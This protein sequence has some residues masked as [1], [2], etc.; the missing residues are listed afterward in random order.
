MS[1]LKIVFH[2]RAY[3]RPPLSLPRGAPRTALDAVPHWFDSED[4]RDRWRRG[5]AR[6][7][8]ECRAAIEEALSTYAEGREPSSTAPAR[9]ACTMLALC[10]RPE[11]TGAFVTYWYK[12]AGF[13]LLLEAIALSWLFQYHQSDPD[14]WIERVATAERFGP[15]PRYLAD[16]VGDLLGAVSND[17]ARVGRDVAARLRRASPLS[18]RVFFAACF[19]EPGWA[20]EDAEE[21]LARYPQIPDDAGTSFYQLSLLLR[22]GDLLSRFIERFISN[23]AVTELLRRA[24]AVAVPAI[25]AWANRTDLSDVQ[26]QSLTQIES[27]DVAEIVE[28]YAR[29]R[30]YL[31][32]VHEYF[33]R[34]PDL[35]EAGGT[36]AQP[37]GASRPLPRSD[38]RVRDEHAERGLGEFAAARPYWIEAPDLL[39]ELVR[40][41]ARPAGLPPT[42]LPDHPVFVAWRT[43]IEALACARGQFDEIDDTMPVQATDSVIGGTVAFLGTPSWPR[44][45]KCGDELELCVEL[46]EVEHREWTRRAGSLV[47]MY[48]FACS[49]RSSQPQFRGQSLAQFVSPSSRVRRTE[50]ARAA[51]RK[52]VRGPR[53]WQL[54]P[55]DWFSSVVRGGEWGDHLEI[56]DAFAVRS[57]VEVRIEDEYKALTSEGR[58]AMKLMPEAPAERLARLEQRHQASDRA[59]REN[60]NVIIGGYPRYLHNDD[61]APG[62]PVCR[63][64]MAFV[65]DLD[66]R[67]RGAC[68]HAYMCDRT[69][70]CSNELQ[71]EI[72]T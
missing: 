53:I 57:G 18:V 33:A 55:P 22:D 3:P 23:V 60:S 51:G 13:D 19:Q 52:V 37:S 65:L 48:C 39:R 36:R 2:E 69:V 24:G 32:L 59:N 4:D 10:T 40:C 17:E 14:V 67:E 15:L 56:M 38:V 64:P 68:L 21:T 45:T 54:T 58:I 42:K 72:E 31:K 44:C 41:D 6:A 8:E 34:R 11:R 1:Q 20:A 29:R 66:I 7:D 28:K 9:V 26:L 63:A 12:R 61:C 46:A 27:H 47:I 5:L 49:P 35:R 62:C 50:P 25:V 70:A 16:T 43:D 30:G 71:L